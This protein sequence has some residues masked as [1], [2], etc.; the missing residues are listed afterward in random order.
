MD[1]ELTSV[2]GGA[3]NGTVTASSDPKNYVIGQVVKVSLAA[4]APGQLLELSVG[5]QGPWSFCNATSAG[6]CGA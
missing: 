3:A 1:F 6:Q 2:A 4:G 5:G